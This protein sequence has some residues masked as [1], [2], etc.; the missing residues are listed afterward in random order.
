[1][2]RVWPDPPSLVGELF[3]AL[4]PPNSSKNVTLKK[5]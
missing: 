4:G 2:V 3:A 5:R 1:M